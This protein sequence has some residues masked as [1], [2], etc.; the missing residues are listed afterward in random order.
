MCCHSTD[1]LFV[2]KRGNTMDENYLDTHICLGCRQ[3]IVGL[4][5]Y[6]QHK[7]YE[8][9]VLKSKD[10]PK[11][12]TTEPSLMQKD[13]SDVH[14]SCDFTSVAT[15]SLPNSGDFRDIAQPSTFAPLS[16][17][18]FEVV[19]SSVNNSQPSATGIVP[20]STTVPAISTSDQSS[21]DL[22]DNIVLLTTQNCSFFSSLQLKSKSTGGQPQPEDKFKSIENVTL[23]E[24]SANKDIGCVSPLLQ[25]SKQL[26]HLC[27]L[28]SPELKIEADLFNTDA[29]NSVQQKN[30]LYGRTKVLEDSM[31]YCWKSNVPESNMFNQ[32]K[33][34][35]SGALPERKEDGTEISYSFDHSKALRIACMFNN[36]EL[37]SDSDDFMPSDAEDLLNFSDMD[38]EQN[39][40]N[41]S[42]G[43]GKVIRERNVLGGKLESYKHSDVYSRSQGKVLRP[44][45][46]HSLQEKSSSKNETRSGKQI[47]TKWR[48]GE[49]PAVLPRYHPHTSRGKWQGP[50]G[51]DVEEEEQDEQDEE[52]DVEERME[53]CR[54]EEEK[55]SSRSKQ[56]TEFHCQKKE[57][58]RCQTAKNGKTK[59][60]CKKLG[61]KVKE[62]PMCKSCNKTFASQQSLEHHLKTVLHR[63]RSQ[64]QAL[65]S[66]S[67][68]NQ[69][70][71]VQME[72]P[73]CDKVFH[74][75]Y[76]FARHL[77]TPMHA[78]RAQYNERHKLIASTGLEAGVQLLM[79]RLQPFQCRI[80]SFHTSE[81]EELM[82]HLKTSEHSERAITLCGPFICVRCQYASEN[83]DD[84]I[85]H[86][87]SAEHV[88]VVKASFQPCV[89]K[90]K[91]CKITCP[92]CD[93][94]INSTSQLANHQK[95]CQTDINAMNRKQGDKL[96]PLKCAHCGAAFLTRFN[97]TVHVRRLHRK[98]K[99]F[100]CR[101]C[102]K[103]FGDD[104]S[105]KLHRQSKHH[106]DADKTSFTNGEAI[107]DP[108]KAEDE[109]EINMHMHKCKQCDFIS[110]TPSG[111]ITHR[112]SHV[113]SDCAICGLRFAKPLDHDK[114]V[115]S[116]Q[117]RKKEEEL[118][119]SSGD[120]FTCDKCPRK[121]YNIRSLKLHEMNH[122]YASGKMPKN[123][124]SGP[125][126]IEVRCR[127][128]V[129]ESKL[130]NGKIECPECGKYL[131]KI[132]ILPHLRAHAGVFPFQCTYCSKKFV[133]GNIMKRH[134]KVHLGIRSY[135]CKFCPREFDRR[136]TLDTHLMREHKDSAGIVAS[137][138]CNICGHK[139][140]QLNQLNAHLKFHDKTVRCPHP[141][142][143]LTFRYQSEMLI[144][145]QVHTKETRFLCDE[146]GYA[147]K[148]KTQL[149]R[150]RRV[151]TGERRYKCSHCSYGAK[152]IANLTRH[153]RVHTG[154]KP[155]QCPYCKY[156][157]NTQENL[158]KHIL[159]TKRHAG[160]PVYPCPKCD[161]GCNSASE[162]QN[163]MEVVHSV[164][165]T[166]LPSMVAGL[167]RRETDMQST[168]NTT[169]DQCLN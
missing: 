123:G 129:R 90:E 102:D 162:F 136:L 161:F 160:K 120:I 163:H 71:R 154:N 12:S 50:E 28:T 63:K 126:D 139:F 107:Q 4:D 85:V 92:D 108:V 44:R 151:H 65:R 18:W 66:E 118:K 60:T 130:S 125:D 37:E 41:H 72:C 121:F 94:V 106:M 19:P 155:Y 127:K 17:T 58:I 35:D 150:H 77:L 53:K 54:E 148:T 38:D 93:M 116:R 89:L 158:R 9:T 32:P 15:S 113:P 157:C 132:G 1:D 57:K 31:T 30:D 80:C 13:T 21:V 24:Y 112:M 87:S 91:R 61:K 101:M 99:S 156:S 5:A 133:D 135:K 142:C 6:I 2:K 16:P 68:Q 109:S 153:E 59:E 52:T 128:L 86:V 22:V 49:R 51:E 140:L 103:V 7:K 149:S 145:M 95:T 146:C 29:P 111:I 42:H 134:L 64:L 164:P 10:L 34:S 115:M 20:P 84:M 165:R 40:F 144:H 26:E 45:K 67:E 168:Q 48:P 166:H 137:H 36:L 138:L 11:N 33:S 88:N 152:H 47:A 39:G 147:G 117:H 3:T 81:A 97:L 79:Q 78:R 14:F 56:L 98:E 27:A 96:E 8:C 75:K 69:P 169:M 124:S 23:P 82:T 105:L 110:D 83:N 167:Y 25:Q 119:V 141:G 70:V 159:K 122:Q 43:D 114:H 143:L 104:S 73:L 74:S 131:T 46:E 100:Q 55:K 76:S 62:K